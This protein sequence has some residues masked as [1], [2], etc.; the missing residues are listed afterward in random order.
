[1]KIFQGIVKSAK[2]KNTAVVEVERFYVHPLY[3]KRV[4]RT[5]G[6][7]VHIGTG[8]FV[9]DTVKFI[10]TSPISKTKKWKITEVIT[11]GKSKKTVEP[12]KEVKP[13]EKEVKAKSS[14]VKAKAKKK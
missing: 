7:A 11:K 2:N 5:K 12:V 14:K 6:Y 8:V 1:M 13:K 4:K 9:G 3:E 10:E